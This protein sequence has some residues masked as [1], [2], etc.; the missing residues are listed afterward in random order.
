M[1]SME[2][3][4]DTPLANVVTVGNQEQR[5]EIYRSSVIGGERTGGSE[6]GSYLRL[7]DFGITQL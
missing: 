3:W 2:V 6:E 4:A 7:I 1:G 5:W